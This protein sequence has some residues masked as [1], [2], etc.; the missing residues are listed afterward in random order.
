MKTLLALTVIAAGVLA[1]GSAEVLAGAT[2]EASDSVS[3]QLIAS[4]QAK[5]Y[6]AVPE[7]KIVKVRLL[8]DCAHG[9]AN[10]VVRLSAVD[11]QSAQD[12]G[13]GD[14]APGAVAYAMTLEQN[15]KP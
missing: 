4:G 7:G 13:L 15:Q 3:E 5:V 6:V 8:V 2:F 12:G 14:S 10:D 1:D 9:R 11:A